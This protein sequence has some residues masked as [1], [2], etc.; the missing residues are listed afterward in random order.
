MSGW[1]SSRAL[2][3]GTTTIT[4]TVHYGCD[5][6]ERDAVDIGASTDPRTLAFQ[7]GPVQRSNVPDLWPFR[8][9]RIPLDRLTSQSGHSELN[10]FQITDDT[11]HK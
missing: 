1:S 9:R 10:A 6:A 3:T 2:V 7:P 5:D 4:I 11:R 8:R